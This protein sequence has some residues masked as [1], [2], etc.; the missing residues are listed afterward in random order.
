MWCNVAPNFDRKRTHYDVPLTP[1]AGLLPHPLLVEQ[2]P[3]ETDVP[4]KVLPDT[5]LDGLDGDDDGGAGDGP[6]GRGRGGLG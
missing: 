6:P 2:R 1:K 4:D 3:L 5:V